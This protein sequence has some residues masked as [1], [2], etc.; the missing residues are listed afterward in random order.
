MKIRD[1]HGVFFGAVSIDQLI[2]HDDSNE[3]KNLYTGLLSLM[4]DVDH[5][6]ILDKDILCASAVKLKHN[7]LPALDITI[8]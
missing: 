6:S 5:K 2:R 1:L 8:E 7:G 4:T 3:Y